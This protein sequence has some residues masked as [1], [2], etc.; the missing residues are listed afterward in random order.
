MNH[1]GASPSVS[2]SEI[3]R[4]ELFDSGLHPKT[5]GLSGALDASSWRLVHLER[6]NAEILE[7]QTAFRL[8]APAI[9]IQPWTSEHR[10]RISA[11]ARGSHVLLGSTALFNAIGHRP[12]SGEL[13]A[14]TETRAL[15]ALGD[16]AGLRDTVSGLVQGILREVAG[17][18]AASRTVVEALLR[19]L[20]IEFWREQ[21]AAQVG[22]RTGQS[23]RQLM[24]RFNSLVEVHFRDR[25][26]VARYAEA[27]GISAD[28]LNDI[29]RREG[30]RAPREI[31]VARTLVEARLLLKNSLHSI[32]QV[33]GLLGFTSAAHFNRFFKAAEGV[34]PGRFRQAQQ[35][36]PPQPTQK[37]GAAL[38]EW[39]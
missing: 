13:R 38:F 37:Q 8:V 34:P 24:A 20:L 22:Q 25:W 10:L 18:G 35:N 6:G 7:A 2:A 30:G 16:K 31:I 19:V 32:D 29:C 26:T 21:G 4:A 28:R 11:G 39:P 3:I 17:G 27:L 33:A 5:I 14:L 1:S 36:V 23:G 9:M 15:V 12:E